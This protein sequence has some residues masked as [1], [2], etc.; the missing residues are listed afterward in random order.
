MLSM[1]LT[2]K[3]NK[4]EKD[5]IIFYEHSAYGRYNTTVTSTDI[6]TALCVFEKDYVHGRIYG[7]MAIE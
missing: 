7:I 6:V 4:M 3:L 5:F 2:T 1:G